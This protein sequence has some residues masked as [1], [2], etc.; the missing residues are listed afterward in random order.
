MKKEVLKQLITKPTRRIKILGI[1]SLVIIATF[2]FSYYVGVVSPNRANAFSG[3]GTGDENNPFRI[4]NCTQLQEMKNIRWA[5]Y[6]LVTDVDCADTFNWNNGSGFL[7]INEFSGTF[8]GRNYAIKDL[9]IN[10]KSFNYA[11]GLF[12]Y[13]PRNGVTIE[14]VRFTK[15]LANKDRID[16]TGPNSVGSVAGEFGGQWIRNVH[17]DLNIRSKGISGSG[18]AVNPSIGGLVGILRGNITHSSSTGSVGL[19]NDSSTDKPN[20]YTVA[21]GLVGYIDDY[22]A[23]NFV[24][25][26]SYSF[27][28]AKVIIQAGTQNSA[29]ACGG[30]IGSTNY[31]RADNRAHIFKSYS[32]GDVTCMSPNDGIIV[33]GFIGAIGFSQGANQL[34]EIGNNFSVSK[35][36]TH[37][38]QESRGFYGGY[39]RPTEFA[40]AMGAELDLSS[41]VYDSFLS[42]RAECGNANNVTCP[43]VDTSIQ[44]DVFTQTNPA[45]YLNGWDS[46]NWVLGTSYPTLAT[47]AVRPNAPT[48]LDVQRDGNDFVLNWTAPS[49]DG[50]RTSNIVDYQIKREKL[51]PNGSYE[52]SG[53]E[54][55]N[56]E[57]SNFRYTDIAVPSKYRFTVSARFTTNFNSGWNRNGLP[58]E[59][60][61]FATGMPATA[62]AGIQIQP[63]AKTAVA[64]WE[65]VDTATNYI[66]QFRRVGDTNWT[67]WGGVT[68]DN[69]DRSTNFF[70]LDP[71]TGYEIRVQANNI[72]GGGPWSEPQ[73]FTTTSQMQYD[74]ATCQQLQDMDNDLEGFYNLTQDVD[75]TGFDFQPVADQNVFMGTIN[76]NGKKIINLTI[77]TS[78][79]VDEPTYDF[80]GVGIIANS[81]NATIQNV[82]LQNPTV[83]VNYTLGQG[84]DD[85]S[86]G[87]PDGPT[88]TAPEQ[89]GEATAPV[90]PGII[91]NQES[92]QQEV[93]ARAS[94]IGEIGND[95]LNQLEQQS[96]IAGDVYTGSAKLAVGGMVG[97]S[98]GENRFDNIR[99]TNG[100]IRGGIVGGIIGLSIPVKLTDA[101]MNAGGLTPTS[102]YVF[103]ELH[104]DGLVVGNV[105]GGVIGA[106]T[107]TINGLFG[108]DGKVTIQNSTSSSEVQGNVAGGLVGVTIGTTG[109][110]IIPA[111]T[112]S[113]SNDFE[114]Q[115]RAAIQRTLGT[116]DV[117]ILNSSAS[118]LVSACDAPSNLRLGVLGGLVGIGLNLHVDGSHSSG[119]VTNCS[120]TNSTWGI[121]GGVMG[122]ISGVSLASRITNSYS[123][124]DILATDNDSVG[125]AT[126]V[127]M[128]VAIT[129]GTTG[130]TLY[131][132][133][134][135]AKGY[136]AI[137]NTYS[138][139]A[140]LLDSKTGFV[141]VSG[142]LNGLYI[143]SGTIRGSHSSGN[144]THHLTQKSRGAISIAGGL[145]GVTG[146]VD[147]PFFS[148]VGFTIPNAPQAPG[149]GL[150]VTDSYATGNVGVQKDYGGGSLSLGGGLMGF[151]IGQ[152]TIQNSYATGNV[153]GGLPDSV[154]TPDDAFDGGVS[155]FIEGIS[156]GNTKYGAAISGGLVGAAYGVDLHRVF[157]TVIYG[158]SN[159]SSDLDLSS[160][161]LSVNNTH[162]S[163]NIKGNLAGGLFGS[164]DLKVNINKSY[165]E[166]NV[167]GA[168][169]GGI[170]GQAGFVNAAAVIGS[171]VFMGISSNNSDPNNINNLKFYAAIADYLQP[172]IGPVT[173]SNTYTTGD[174]TGVPGLAKINYLSAANNPDGEIVTEPI[175]LPTTVGG[176][177]GLFM[178]PGG[179]ITDSYT[180]GT[181]NVKADQDT[182]VPNSQGKQI[183][184]IGKVPNFAGGVVGFDIALPSLDY[185][186]TMDL[187]APD[188]DQQGSPKISDFSDQ[189]HLI[190]NVFSASK[191]NLNSSSITGGSLGIVVS[192]MDYIN[193]FVMGNGPDRLDRTK[194]YQMD[195]VYLDKSKVTVANCNGPGKPIASVL[196]PVLDETKLYTGDTGIMSAKDLLASDE[197]ANNLTRGIWDQIDPILGIQTAC[198]YVNNNN[199]DS[200]YF[201]QNKTNAPMNQWNF[202][203]VWNVRKDDYP[204]FVAGAQDPD[205]NVV[206]DPGTGGNGTGSGTRRNTT[207][208]NDLPA[209]PNN[210]SQQIQEVA[211]KAGFVR[212]PEKVK[213]L[214]AILARVPVFI[215]K[216]IPYS[217]VLILLA[218][219]I[220]YSYQAMREYRQLSVYHAAITR[221][222]NTKESIDSYLA[223]TTHY[224]NTPVA[225]MGGA[226]E[227]LES[228]KKISATKASS[229]KSKIK[230]FNDAASGL[231]TSNQVSNAQS[232]NDEKL[233]KHEQ[234]S[235]LKAKAVWVPSVIALGLLLLANALFMY[236]D[237]FNKSPYRILVEF[238]LYGLGVFLVALAYRYRNFMAATKDIAKKQLAMESQLYQRRQ[239]FIPE[240]IKVVTEHYEDLEIAG[241]P[242]K[243]IPEAKL[244][245]NGLNMLGGIRDGLSNIKKFAN[246]EAEAPLFD[247]T[248]YMQKAVHA[249]SAKAGDKK[250][251]FDAN[252]AP[253][254]VGYIQPEAARQIVDS[255]LDN[256]VK[257][258]KEGGHIQVSAYQRLNKLVFSVSDDG[259]GISENKLPS[260]L[261]PFSR[262]T[263]SMEYNY[264]GLGL[265]L[266]TDKIITNRLGGT[267]SIQSEL[268]KGTIVT[269]TI[270]FQHEAKALAPVLITPEATA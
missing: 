65:A 2:L 8:D 227:L 219:A 192:P 37:R 90:D 15:S 132:A 23:S 213:G 142:G 98:I 93:R 164:A 259:V 7:P 174:I 196:D 87:L 56:S 207:T 136:S 193:K 230:R 252:I 143:G 99:T 234:P 162:T 258:S 72:A 78:R 269:I 81:Y 188:D 218:L 105:S 182:T 55:V 161:G 264:E 242:L 212:T 187:I 22:E 263:D 41:N 150:L 115:L 158:T 5:N 173:I 40:Q 149:R 236:A 3:T 170:V 44:P 12:G 69:S 155:K 190:K 185:T 175:R 180:A 148:M 57:T 66:V 224:L 91:T 270:P 29:G 209:V 129:G 95:L 256:A 172:A 241:E 80:S 200:R 197:N 178:A 104:S 118:G 156:N 166:G 246:F 133:D 254:L 225:I 24:N 167:D 48:N 10:N 1:A 144:I 13:M 33:G 47:W 4:T 106:T 160:Q 14:N 186:K 268:G 32:T 94:T 79:T 49:G 261:K 52:Y 199:S 255:L 124:G 83:V 77:D 45:G 46:P 202:S 195:A 223:I 60:Y 25:E 139:G 145:N 88:I 111:V 221:I 11:T 70:E 235:P 28:T 35:V 123:T 30:L 191:M 215:A 102:N 82:T 194:V 68:A 184:K 222:V 39:A 59:T 100:M 130:I 231:L 38:A 211:R 43:S 26:V 53:E 125:Q 177:A 74:V 153:T 189:P 42:G 214:K 6:V 54:L 31:T 121:Y 176:I 216:S 159:G 103:N 243:K 247:V 97:I 20:R 228:L 85:D 107:G 260:L 266:Y 27:S 62:P 238:G 112:N 117:E 109:L 71:A 64:A 75:C 154:Q 239:S 110:G 165:S 21:G 128:L 131:G 183:A 86:N 63:K 179:S 126:S 152:G 96:G 119:N 138:T 67:Y 245:L 217:L 101:L 198:Q 237:V 163:G 204:K 147:L 201:I 251:T 58:S 262:G 141:G 208:I 240:A 232:S 73:P 229:L 137:E 120:R 210:V 89:L 34:A 92:A 253:G 146:S 116:Q 206:T 151:F 249:Q 169:A 18:Q 168:I 17:S 135:D 36:T 114:A 127:N 220:M 248:T 233:V 16:I 203:S 250:I 84:V 113:N 61:E 76:G 244:F 108:Q 226:V 205:P 134:D 140:T 267:L 51:N 50:S 9:Y 257:F 171:G 265:G 122:G 19:I 157:S 181:V